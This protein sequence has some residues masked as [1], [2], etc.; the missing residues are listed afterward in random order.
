MSEK[1]WAIC[2]L[3]VALLLYPLALAALIWIWWTGKPAL[4]GVGVLVAI[5]LID[6]TWLFLLR[7]IVSIRK[8]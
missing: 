3:C 6:R 8:Q 4:W 5:L 1:L 2:R 7:R